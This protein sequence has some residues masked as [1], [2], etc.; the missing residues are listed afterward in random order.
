MPPAVSD[1]ITPSSIPTNVVSK[2]AS[3]PRELLLEI[4]H[5]LPVSAMISLKLVSKELYH[6]TILP[7]DYQGKD[8]FYKLSFCERNAI[9][10]NLNERRDIKDG[11]RRCLLCN[12]LQPAYVFTGNGATCD[13]HDKRFMS[14]RFPPGLESVL[15]RRLVRLACG[16]KTCWVAIKRRLCV[17]TRKIVQWEVGQCRCDCE[18]CPHVGV[19]CY[20]RVA[21]QLDTPSTW[22]LAHDENGRRSI[23]ETYE[24]AGKQVRLRF[25]V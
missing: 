19:S 23:K 25:S 14:I 20:V 5:Y 8:A 7:L 21:S 17:H 10:R 11:R 15:C 13:F 6:T 22:H 1:T 3:L 16:T 2:L 4:T 18:S 12:C 9:R 24:V